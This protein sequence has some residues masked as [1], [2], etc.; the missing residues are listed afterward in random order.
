M[1]FAENNPDGTPTMAMGSPPSGIRPRLGNTYYELG[2]SRSTGR[3]GQCRWATFAISDAANSSRT[4][5]LPDA[6][7]WPVGVAR[8]VRRR[9]SNAP[10]QLTSSFVRGSR[11]VVPGSAIAQAAK[12]SA[13]KKVDDM[14]ARRFDLRAGTC[15]P[16]APWCRCTSRLFQAVSVVIEHV[17]GC[18]CSFTGCPD[19]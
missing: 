17:N 8:I 4:V 12:A 14:D 9:I 10:M 3:R 7:V 18:F 6:R 5:H 13:V 19:G 15:P 2:V 16:A 11:L 1:S